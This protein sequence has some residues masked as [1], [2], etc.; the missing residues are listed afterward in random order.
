MCG[1]L[2]K[3]AKLLFDPTKSSLTSARSG[4]R[5]AGLTFSSISGNWHKKENLTLCG[6]L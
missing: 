3:T 6:S 1:S 4:Q 2:Q 5:E